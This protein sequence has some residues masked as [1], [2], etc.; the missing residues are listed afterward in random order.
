M[1]KTKQVTGSVTL[2]TTFLFQAWILQHFPRI[3]DW[4]SVPEYIEDMPRATAFISLRRNQTIEPFRVYLDRLIVE[5]IYFNNYVDHRQTQ[6]FDE[7]VL[8]SRWLACGSCLAAP[9]L[10]ECVMR[11][12]G[13]VQIIPRHSTV[14]PPPALTRRQIEEMF[15]DYESH[16]VSD[17]A[18]TIT[19]SDWSFVDRYIRWFLRMSHSYMVHVTLEDPPRPS[20]QEI[21]EEEQ[22]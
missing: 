13:Y 16:M 10:F 1:W 9:H 14:F 18:R 15:H 4:A 6:P 8:Y 17:E 11:Q 2:L 22:A 7:I 3:S 5:D 12:F 19:E 21:L 20:H